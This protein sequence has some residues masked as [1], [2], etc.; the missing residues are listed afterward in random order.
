[1][2]FSRSVLAGA[3]LSAADVVE[4]R[5]VGLGAGGIE[6]ESGEVQLEAGDHLGSRR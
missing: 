2:A 4:V 6:R 1:M 5:E 3:E